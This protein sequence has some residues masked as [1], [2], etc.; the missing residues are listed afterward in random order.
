MADGHKS[1]ALSFAPRSWCRRCCFC[2]FSCRRWCYYA[3]QTLALATVANLGGNDLCDAL[4]P[5]SWCCW[6]RYRCWWCHC[7][8]V[9]AAPT[10]VAAGVGFAAA[11]PPNGNILLLLQLD[12]EAS[13]LTPKV[14]LTP[15]IAASPFPP[16]QPVHHFRV[17]SSAPLY[18]SI[19]IFGP[20]AFW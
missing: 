2:C 18:A 14:N 10:F 1:W 12:F 4:L 19:G 13:L 7:C 9:A 20:L 5:V 17:T 3:A 11:C 6:C 8:V 16:P 15:T